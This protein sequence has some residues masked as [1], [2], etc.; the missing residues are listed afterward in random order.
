MGSAYPTIA[1]DALSRFYRMA[2]AHPFLITGCDEHGEKIA[3]AAAAA[4]REAGALPSVDPSNAHVQQFCDGIAAQFEHLWTQLSIRHDSFIRTTSTSHAAVVRQFMERVWNNGDIYK[5]VYQGLYCTGCEEYKDEKD[6]LH[7]NVCPSHCTPCSSRTEENY[8]FALSKYQA[9]LEQFLEENPAFVLPIERRNEVLGWVKSGLRDFSVSRAYNTWGIPVPRDNDQTIYVWFDALLGYISA[10]LQH[11]DSS[12]LDL[13]LS[14]G[15][16]ADVHIIGKDILR[17]HAVYW[18]AMLM[19]AG[20]PLPRRVVGHGFITKD[21]MKMGKSLGNTLDPGDLVDNYGSDAVRYYFLKA[22]EFG[23]D[24]DFSEQRFV[25]IVNA[26]LANSLGNLLNRSLNLLKKNCQG[27]LPMSSEVLGLEGC[28][29]D[30]GLLRQAAASAAHDAFVHYEQLDFV[31]ACESI[32]AISSEANA[33]IDRVAPWSK[34]KSDDPAE[35]EI[36][37]RCIVNVL[38]GS[39]IVAAGLYP[40]VPG[41]SQKI[42]EALG[43][44]SLFSQG[45]QWEEAMQWGGLKEGMSFS[46]PKPV[47]PR[48]EVVC[49][50]A[51][52]VS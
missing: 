38:E 14:K 33:Y 4:A 26:D 25:D 15:W 40:V 31:A 1:A 28:H 51:V 50:E 21:G 12:D 37:A 10:L 27:T 18:P 52:G 13:A 30:E 41:L 5:S 49:Q 29:N 19:S 39:R 23:R 16:P 17:F 48:L 44:G 32:I 47:F 3:A 35:V 2:G 11:S 20:F 7:G 8:F 22:V 6:L 9:K 43:L 24:G 42:Y 34:F 46:K 36:A 45:L